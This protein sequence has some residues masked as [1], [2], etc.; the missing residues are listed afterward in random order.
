MVTLKILIVDDEDIIRDGLAK[1]ILRLFPGASIIG[2]APNARI[3]LQLIEDHNPNIVITDIRMPEMDGLQLISKVRLLRKDIKFVIVSGYQDFEYARSAISLGVEDYLLKPV[4]NDKLKEIILKLEQKLDQELYNEQYIINLKEK[5]N[6][7]VDFLKNKYLTDILNYGNESDV[8]SIFKN[9]S[10]VGIN[11]TAKFFTVINITIPSYEN[12]PMFPQKEDIP[13]LKFAIKNIAEETLSNTGTAVAFENLKMERQIVV[14]VCHE[15]ALHSKENSEICRL[16][17]SLLYSLNKYLSLP[18]V[19]GIGGSYET[20]AGL[21]NSYYDSYMAVMQRIIV[22]DNK[23][24]HIE[25]VPGSNGIT[26][27]L[28]EEKRI[29]LLNHV[30]EGNHKKANELIDEIFSLIEKQNLSYKNIKAIYADLIILL[31]KTLKGIGGSWDRIF[32]EDILSE[33]FLSHYASLGSLC[34][35]LKDCIV[36]ICNYIGELQRS[37]GKKVIDEIK[38]YIDNYY[39]T[40]INLNT[41][42]ARYYI[43]ASY[44]SQLFKMELE[45]NFI[46][47]VTKVRIEKAMDL[48]KNS[49]FKAYKVGEMVGYNN[50]RYFSD[51]FQ[52]CTGMTP[53]EFRKKS[54][55]ILN[56]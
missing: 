53:I 32:H 38:A 6:Q 51:L 55:R 22:G 28:Q 24:I 5:A 20:A 18:V 35:W 8:N 12:N 37:E 23:V 44:L 9:L 7:S 39:Y 43:N 14:I 42:A 21:P 56:E 52:K 49:G 10:I 15:K 33:D 3:A 4:E 29:L 46:D 1:K 19:I 54:N 16:C 36:S 41:L 47:Y 26:Y 13:V 34:L 30:K 45:E 2:K 25:N 50:P 11:F 31:M 40:E 17:S 27:L 48:L